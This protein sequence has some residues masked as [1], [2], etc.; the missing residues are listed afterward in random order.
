MDGSKDVRKSGHGTKVSMN[1]KNTISTWKDDV[2]TT[3]SEMIK[4]QCIFKLSCIDEAC[5]SH[6]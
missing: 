5:L 4:I 6:K 3:M 2:K 1:P